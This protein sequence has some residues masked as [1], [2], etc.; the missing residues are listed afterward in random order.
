MSYKWI[1]NRMARLLDFEA[2][3]SITSSCLMHGKRGE[4][5][6][7][8][9][10]CNRIELERFCHRDFFWEGCSRL[11]KR[12]SQETDQTPILGYSGFGGR[13]GQLLMFPIRHL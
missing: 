8:P 2:A 11:V 4:N 1:D 10:N 9:R 7:L 12:E 3:P 13:A 6:P 5:P